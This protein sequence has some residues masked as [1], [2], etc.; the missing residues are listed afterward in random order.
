M[1]NFENTSDADALPE[2]P[3]LP[4]ETITEL[5][6]WMELNNQELQKLIGNKPTTGQ[7][8]CLRLIHGGEIYVHTNSDGDVLLDVTPEAEWV[9][10]VITACTQ[11]Q[12]PRGQIWLV[13]QFS[14]TGLLLGLNSL[15]AATRLVLK[16][17]YRLSR[18]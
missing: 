4:F 3:W 8:I 9:A 14:L 17:H 15:I 5:E 6:G 7:G 1:K 12:P 11:V 18:F 16:H 2:Y 10:P 13:P